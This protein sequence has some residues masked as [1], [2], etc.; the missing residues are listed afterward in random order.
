MLAA[1]WEIA[2]RERELRRLEQEL[3]AAASTVDVWKTEAHR[4]LR[5]A[6]DLGLLAP[7]T[8][9]PEE[10][11][12]ILGLLRAITKATSR[13]ARPT[14][15]ALDASLARLEQ[16]RSEETAAAVELSENRKRY[17]EIRRL[18]Q[19]SESYGSAIRVERDRLHLSRWL[20][21]RVGP[22]SD[23]LVQ[24]SSQGRQ[25]IDALCAALEGIE[26]RVR[27]HPTMSDTLDRE[28]IRLSASVERSIQRL[29]QIR[30]EIAVLEQESDETSESV[31]RTDQVDRFSGKTRARNRIV[32]QDGGGRQLATTGLG[33]IC[34]DRENSDKK[35]LKRMR[36]GD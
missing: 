4:W 20:R 35:C 36:E 31:Y 19:S 15:E 14:L 25:D 32:R 18:L 28:R 21:S 16:L 24:V 29:T 30:Q 33:S 17:N 5:Q 6:M 7:G 11:L 2:Q 27:S 23:A 9:L 3:R 1:R 26:M 12:E 34:S 10:W 8:S 22:S 13:S